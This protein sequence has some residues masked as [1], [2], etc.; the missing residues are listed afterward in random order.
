MGREARCGPGRVALLSSN[1][2]GSVG[3]VSTL[4]RHGP[5]APRDLAHGAARGA[6]RAVRRASC[7]VC[8]A[9]RGASRPGAP[10]AAGRVPCPVGGS[11]RVRAE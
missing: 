11:L 8:R 6:S 10:R 9:L 4:R 2:I 5:L 1:L 7:G 3:R